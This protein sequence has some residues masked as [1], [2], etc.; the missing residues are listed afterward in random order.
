MPGTASIKISCRLPSS[1]AARTV[2]P[3]VLPLGRA[4]EFTSPE[5]SI[6]SVIARIGIVFVA[7]CAARIATSPQATMTSTLALTRSPAYS[8]LSSL[9][10]PNSWQLIVRFWPLMKPQRRISSDKAMF[11]GALSHGNGATIP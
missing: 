6:S 2:T 9:F 3:V 8:E 4:N 5:P 1:S 10:A 7:C 11:M